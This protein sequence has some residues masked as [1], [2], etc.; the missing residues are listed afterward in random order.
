[1]RVADLAYK[2]F[3][4]GGALTAQSVG[5]RFQERA[6]EIESA[7]ICE[8]ARWGDSSGQ[9]G[10]M[11]R[12]DHWRP[13]VRRIAK[14]YIPQRSDIVLGQLYRHGLIP[15]LEAPRL[16]KSD[17][18]VK[19]GTALRLSSSSGK[20]YFMLDGTDPRMIG[21]EIHPRAMEYTAPIQLKTDVE[22]QARTW[23]DGEW[24]ALAE[25]SYSVKAVL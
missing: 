5:R 3:F 1:M 7:V 19:A 22:L 20:I 24:S 14:E 15:D 17:G 21:G 23:L 8:S 6:K 11:N 10:S 25:G 12:D 16:S 13:E 9:S 18:D 4:N 2:R